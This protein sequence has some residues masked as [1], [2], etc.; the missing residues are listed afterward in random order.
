LVLK[1]LLVVLRSGI[2]LAGAL[3]VA[4]LW[5]GMKQKQVNLLAPK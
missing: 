3:I 1:A 4:E 2:T 5:S